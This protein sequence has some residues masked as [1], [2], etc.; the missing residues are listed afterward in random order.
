MPADI[1]CVGHASHDISVYVAEF[2]RENSKCETRDL[3][4]SGGGPAANA[5]YL[6]ALWGERCA[7]AA[8]AGDDDYGRRLR[9]ELRSAGAEVSLVELR[10]GHATPVSLILIN[11]KNGSRTIVNRKAPGEP[12]QCGFDRLGWSP[13]TLLFDGHELAASLD[14]LRA[15]PR[16]VSV[17]DAGS[18]RP[19]TERLAGEVDYL[20]ASERFALQATGLADLHTDDAR[21]ECVRRLRERHE[22]TVI[23]T[24]GE[25][26]LV[27]DEGNGFFSLPAWPAEAVDTTAA[28]DIF[29][30]ALVWALAR[31]T[32]LMDG[33]RLASMAASLSVRERGGRRSIPSLARVREA[34]AYAE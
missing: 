17:L 18:L 33:L 25:N 27:G 14:A 28:G 7:L 5:A 21:R 2:P 20:A 16:A 26:G 22:T 24:M 29:H 9:E 15:F 11:Q 31:K 32:P 10:P 23:V 6:L 19:G 30:G 4:E 13:G 12:L 8:L 3:L 1:L 34:L